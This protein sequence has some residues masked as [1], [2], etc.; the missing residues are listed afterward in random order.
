ML[1]CSL[2]VSSFSC[3]VLAYCKTLLTQALIS[4]QDKISPFHIHMMQR[5]DEN[6]ESHTSG[7]YKLIQYQILQSNIM[8]EL[9][10][11]QQGEL[12]VRYWG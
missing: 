4:D 11:R 5:S 3:D 2:G 7:D 9:F 6:K 12:S 10:G 1:D 8:E